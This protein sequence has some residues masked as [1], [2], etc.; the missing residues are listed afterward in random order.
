M[1]IKKILHIFRDI[2]FNLYGFSRKGVFK[3]EGACMQHEPLGFYLEI[4][5]EGILILP[6][7]RIPD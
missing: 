2:R 4:P 5:A 1:F 6:Q 7:Y 3:F